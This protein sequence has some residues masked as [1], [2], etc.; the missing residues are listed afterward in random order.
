MLPMWPC[1][2]EQDIPHANPSLASLL[3][4]FKEYTIGSAVGILPG[5]CLYV[6]IGALANNIAQVVNGD[7]DTAPWIL[8]LTGCISIIFLVIVVV[9]LTR[10]A[11]KALAERIEV[12]AEQQ[13]GDVA[14]ANEAQLAETQPAQTEVALATS[15]AAPAVDSAEAAAPESGDASV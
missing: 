2:A 15:A 3:V 6:A 10:Y 7:V 8:I 9:I 4:Q 5:V 1:T 14:Q 12:A 13:G 11:K